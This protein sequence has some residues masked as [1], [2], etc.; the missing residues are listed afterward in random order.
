MSTTVTLYHRWNIEWG[1]KS[2]EFRTVSW[3]TTHD[4]PKYL[5]EHHCDRVHWRYPTDEADICNV[6]DK[7]VEA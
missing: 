7:L 1:W 2:T 3:C 4:S 5:Y 6:V